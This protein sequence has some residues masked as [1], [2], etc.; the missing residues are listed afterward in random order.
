MVMLKSE[1]QNSYSVKCQKVLHLS[2]GDE[3]QFNQD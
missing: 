2:V 3:Q 1:P